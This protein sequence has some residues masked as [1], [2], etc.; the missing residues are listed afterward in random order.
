MERAETLKR[1]NATLVKLSERELT[2]AARLL[3][4]LQKG[5]LFV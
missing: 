2:L 4:D 5:G 1:I 3:E